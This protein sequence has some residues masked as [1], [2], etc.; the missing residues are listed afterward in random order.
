MIRLRRLDLEFFGRFSGKSFDF[1]ARRDAG[2]P[3][4]HVI[5]GLNEAGKTTTME[6]YLRLLYGFPHRE[7]YDFLHQR[8]NLRVSGLL[9]ID[10]AETAF[11][12]LPT[13][14][15]SLRDAEGRELPNK[16]LQAHLGGLS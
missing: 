14:D 2:M 9:D 8:K 10:G 3:D 5:Y 1:G 11:K 4:F 16:A 15:P 7:P 6:G 12:R 13:R